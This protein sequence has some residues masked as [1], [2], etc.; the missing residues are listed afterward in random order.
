MDV[1]VANIDNIHFKIEIELNEQIGAYQLPFT[2][3][4]KSSMAI[5][6]YYN[7]GKLNYIPLNVKKNH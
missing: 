5:C 6:G 4:D 1:I 3:M 7:Q 2:G